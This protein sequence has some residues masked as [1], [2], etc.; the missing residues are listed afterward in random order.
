MRKQK[1]RF[2]R[3]KEY[4]PERQLW[5]REERNAKRGENVVYVEHDHDA[6]RVVYPYAKATKENGSETL[7]QDLC[8]ALI[9]PMKGI[10]KSA[11]F[12]G[13]TKPAAPVVVGD[14]NIPAAE[15]YAEEYA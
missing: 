11:E 9:T 3:E 12:V 2:H 14:A 15:E 1:D 7:H 13:A 6:W 8:T 5:M 4:L 10:V